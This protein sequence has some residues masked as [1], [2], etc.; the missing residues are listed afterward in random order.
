MI[1]SF[2]SSL[3]FFLFL[4][5]F[6]SAVLSNIT[7]LPA[8][9]DLMLIMTL[10]ISLH[11]GSMLGQTTG[12]ASGLMID[13]LSAGPL[14]LN[15]LI[16]TIMGYLIGL[17]SQTLNTSGFFLPALYGLI[18]TIVKALILLIISFFFPNGIV[19]YS[20]FS[21]VFLF[22]LIFNTLLTPVL[23][24]FLNIFSNILKLKPEV[25]LQ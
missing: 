8:V 3:L 18:V 13:F 11:N 7:F 19:T 16:R 6:Q 10:Y 5:L 4:L 14:G 23:F 15:A 12:F 20:L 25:N 9:P 22:E 2:F 24:A 21:Y 1:R 17:L